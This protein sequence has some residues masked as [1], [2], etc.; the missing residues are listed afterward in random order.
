M[1]DYNDYYKLKKQKN[2]L[3]EK[4]L[5]IK[6]NIFNEQTNT[7]NELDKITL[8]NK[9]DFFN[10]MKL[11]E[12]EMNE[13]ENKYKENIKN[14][15]IIQEKHLDKMLSQKEHIQEVY[16]K[17]I[18]KIEI[19]ESTIKVLQQENIKYK[20]TLSKLQEN[21]DID[22]IDTKKY[23]EIEM[24]KINKLLEDIKIQ[25]M[26]LQDKEKFLHLRECELEKRK[27]NPIKSNNMM[28]NIHEELKII[29]ST[30]D[31]INTLENRELKLS[32]KTNHI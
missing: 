29:S 22:H 14:M 5:K 20:I 21:I 8:H 3:L 18:K 6:Q 25:K 26:K 15:Q 17:Y 19:H 30:N 23:V 11:K 31:L 10:I 1:I 13:R 2:I 4:H 12:S 28:S 24:V 32:I 16:K 27:F 9:K 7:A